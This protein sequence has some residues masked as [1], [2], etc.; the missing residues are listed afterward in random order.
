[1]I[2]HADFK[3]LFVIS[4]P[5]VQHKLTRMRDETCPTGE[6]R[7]LLREI[8]LLMGYEVTR[9]LPLTRKT[10]DTPMMEMHAPT[11]DGP[12]PTVVP[13]LRAGLGM[14]EGIVELIPDCHIGHVG[15][16]RDEEK[17]RP[18]EYLVR[19]PKSQGNLYIVT[20]PMLATGH[21]AEHVCEVLEK[22]GVD[23][24]K[25]VLMC[26]VSAPEG[27]RVMERKYAHVPIYTASLDIG[28][29]EQAYIMPGLGDAGDRLFGTY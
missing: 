23:S 22:N 25:I 3:N 18:V 24:K 16:Y 10:I 28:L 27:V 26:L 12:L 11:L 2:K 4:H 29:N 15:V 6:F 19:L 9:H 7:R 1:M 21:S 17:H 8:S 14:A 5:L 20:D 13:I